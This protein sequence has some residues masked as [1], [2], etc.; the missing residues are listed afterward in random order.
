L[1]PE[2]EEYLLGKE[3]G[4]L[5]SVGRNGNPTVVPVCFVYSNGMIYTAIDRKP[6]TKGT[7]ARTQNILR[8]KTVAFV[9]DEYSD[10]WRRLSYALFHGKATILADSKE[11]RMAASM[12]VQKYPQYKWL[13]LKESRIIRIRV[14]KAKLWRFSGGVPNQL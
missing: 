4:F 9:V 8:N 12:L 10:D 3:R 6:K 14:A 13:G 11:N 5:A 2:V 1:I 7:L